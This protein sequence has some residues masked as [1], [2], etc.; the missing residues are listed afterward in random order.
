MNDL[1]TVVADDAAGGP[2]KLLT[3]SLYKVFGP[4]PDAAIELAQKGAAKDEIFRK[5]S[6]V[7]AVNDIT[8]AVEAR[9]IFV[10]MGLSGSGK[11]TLIRCLNRLFDPSSGSIEID[12]EDI[13]GVDN[14]T[15]RQV[16]LNKMTMVFQHFA[17]LPHRSVAENVE[18]GLKV[19]GLDP[20]VRRERAM[21]ALTVVGLDAWADSY[22]HNLSGG[23]QQRVG[24]ARALA[25]DPEIMLMDEPF[26]ALDP[27]IRRDMQDELLRIQER[28]QTTIVFITHDLGEALRLGNQVAIMKDGHFVQVGRPDEIVT[29]PADDYVSAFTQD[30]DRG[31]VLSVGSILRPVTALPLDG[32]TVADVR[33]KF[34]E[35]QVDAI[36]AT[37]NGGRPAGIV[38][39]RDVTTQDDSSG[40][41][42]LLRNDFPEVEP[43]EPIFEVYERCSMGLPLAVVDQDQGRLLGVVTPIDI[44]AALNAADQDNPSDAAPDISAGAPI[45]GG[46]A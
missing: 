22:P 24:L 15:L 9:E 32:A 1:K 25:V 42:D 35:E 33:R 8:M 29:Q 19:R 27:L 20:A 13:V 44:F 23:M 31:R 46:A 34:Q 21:E 45:T 2:P 30:V 14:E 43:E 5:T 28:Y 10:V 37:D 26:S 38:L 40:I 16:R 4:N 3:K 12:G 17:L 41:K 39:A 18:Y 36:Y 11:S 6:S 7:V